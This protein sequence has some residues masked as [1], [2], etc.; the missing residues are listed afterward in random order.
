MEKKLLLYFTSFFCGMSVMAV[1]LSISKLLA[2]YFGTSQIIWT[3]IIGLIMISLSI[4]NILGGRSA[5]G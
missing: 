5:G 2:P 1:E 3:V 4:G